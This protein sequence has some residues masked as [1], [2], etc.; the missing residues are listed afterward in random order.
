MRRD[1][2][3]EKW[4]EVKRLVNERD[5]HCRLLDVITAKEYITLQKKARRLLSHCDPAHILPVSV[6]PHLCYVVENVILLN[7]YSH[8]MLDSCRSPIT[9]E[10]ITKEERDGWWKRIIG[11]DVYLKLLNNNRSENMEEKLEEIK[12]NGAIITKE[13]LEEKKKDK[14]IRLIEETPNSYR[15]LTKMQE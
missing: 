14:S 1:S 3:D 4:K 5:S 8:D 7:R 15:V 12:L 10:P 11:E 6:Y 13:E 2:K 9:G